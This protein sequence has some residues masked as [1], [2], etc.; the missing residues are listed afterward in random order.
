MKCT[1]SAHTYTQVGARQVACHERPLLVLPLTG[2]PTDHRQLNPA[3]GRGT[4]VGAA[5]IAVGHPVQVHQRHTSATFDE[6]L[7]RLRDRDEQCR[8]CR[9]FHR[10]V[11]R[12]R[13]GGRRRRADAWP[14]AVF[15]RDYS[16]SF[17]RRPQ[18]KSSRIKWTR[19]NTFVRS[20]WSSGVLRLARLLPGEAGGVQPG[21]AASSDWSQV[22]RRS[23]S[24]P[25]RV[26]QLMREPQDHP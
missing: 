26:V 24:K 23:S 8:R 13:S 1:P 9:R 5:R 25:F 12:S 4:R 6:R 3:A 7:R 16:L 18:A 2:W 11:V 14:L 22:E 19:D 21:E 17:R 20:A 10:V 15:G